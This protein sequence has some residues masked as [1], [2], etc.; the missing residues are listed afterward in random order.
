ML[1]GRSYT[2]EGILRILRK[3]VWFLLVPVSVAAAGTAMWARTLPDIYQS[4]TTIL[5]VPQR[6]SQ[7]LV[8]STIEVRIEERLPAIEQAIRSRTRLEGLIEEFD[9]YETERRQMV[10]EDVVALM[11]SHIYVNV[12]RPDAFTVSYMG[13]D[14]VKVMRV[15]DRLG[16]LFIDQSLSYRNNLTEDTDEFLESQLLETR[17]ALEEQERRLENYRRTY[18]GQLP[19]Q[20]DANLQQVSTAN[21][22]VQRAVD[23]INQA[24]QRRLLVEQQLAN[25]E[26]VQ[27]ADLTRAMAEGAGGAQLPGVGGAIAEVNAA[28]TAL[29]ALEARG[30][31]PGHPDLDAARR[32]LRD[33][34][35]RLAADTAASPGTGASS[36]S[37][38]EA[39][40]QTRVRELRAEIAELD[41]QISG[42]RLEEERF[43]AAADAAQGRLEALPTRETEMVGLMRD[44]DII[45]ETYRS[46]LQKKEEARISA[47]LERR[48]VGEQF[49]VLDPA[50]VPE[51]PFYPNRTRLNLMGA[52]LGLFA[53]LGMVGLFEYRDR[54]LHDEEDVTSVLGLPVLAVVP[55]MMS[56]DDRR[57]SFRRKLLINLAC[58]TVVVALAAVSAYAYL[59]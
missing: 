15:A 49:N 37:P 43:R 27:P 46:L 48:Q 31:K 19:N 18:A 53:G 4:Q 47:N 54:S 2:P 5:V 24:M 32:A 7:S 11:N 40:R 28:Q 8:R 13:L 17:Q 57:S 9:L 52:V 34:E 44:Y 6:I 10:M 16:T 45:N 50:R 51:R 30:L 26:R 23:S 21:M 39:A 59:N 58:G 56:D 22:Q 38:A 35:A 36:V 14:P 25:L 41:R 1:P 20:V 33:A 42:A 12:I 29:E 55:V 3:N